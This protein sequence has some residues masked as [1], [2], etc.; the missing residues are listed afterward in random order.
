[1]KRSCSNRHMLGSL[2][3]VQRRHFE[4]PSASS[5]L[6]CRM[7]CHREVKNVPAL[8]RQHQEHI[9]DLKANRR[10]GEEINRNEALE[11][12]FQ[13]RSPSLEG[14]FRLRTR[15]LLTLISPISMPSLTSSPWIRGAPQPGFPRLMRRI[16]S[17]ISRDTAGRPGLPRHTFQVQNIRHAL[18]CQAMTVP[19][20][21]MTKAERHSVHT[22]ES[23]IHNRRSELFNSRRFFAEH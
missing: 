16:S 11:V 23:P 15:Y 22:R 5:P 4:A 3:R 6:S 21:T 12:V 19:G 7:C 1:M 10:H 14:G 13:E 18:R 2:D 17:R 9:Q 20:L 8:M